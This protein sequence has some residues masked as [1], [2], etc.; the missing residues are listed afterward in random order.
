[1]VELDAL[2]GQP[3]DVGRVVDA[4]TVAADGLGGM[5]I[6]ENEDNVGS[7]LGHDDWHPECVL[8]L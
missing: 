2:V 7:T 3:V 4:G 1:V 6:S 8:V 5:V